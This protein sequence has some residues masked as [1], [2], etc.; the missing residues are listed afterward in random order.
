MLEPLV[1][2]LQAALPH[3]HPNQRHVGVENVW[4]PKIRFA[5]SEIG[6][7]QAGR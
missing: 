5:P 3:I 7:L 1:A 4:M 6:D 2:R